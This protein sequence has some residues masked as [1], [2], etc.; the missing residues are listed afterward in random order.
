MADE[1]EQVNDVYSLERFRYGARIRL[2]K[3]FKASKFLHC[4]TTLPR[5]LHVTSQV[6]DTIRGLLLRLSIP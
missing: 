6:H 3:T 1:V 5:K 2:A 4:S